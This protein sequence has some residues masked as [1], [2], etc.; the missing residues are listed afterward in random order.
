MW[1]LL[2]R[3]GLPAVAALRLLLSYFTQLLW[4]GWQSQLTTGTGF[5]QRHLQ[6]PPW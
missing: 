4:Q 6:P 3:L 1:P 2:K 5:A